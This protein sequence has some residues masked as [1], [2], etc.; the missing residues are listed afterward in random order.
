MDNLGSNTYVNA[1][2]VAL[3]E[4]LSLFICNLFI[5]KLPRKVSTMAFMGACN[6]MCLLSFAT[7]TVKAL[8]T[9]NAALIRVA[10][11]MTTGILAV[12]V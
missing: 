2:I 4:T 9:V 11:C 8:Q 5:E 6:V 12:Y 1:V 7:R 10:N 3:G